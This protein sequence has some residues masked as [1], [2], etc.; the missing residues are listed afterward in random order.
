M[1]AFQSNDSFSIHSSFIETEIVKSVISIN[2]LNAT[3]QTSNDSDDVVQKIES[4]TFNSSKTSKTTLNNNTKD[5]SIFII[6]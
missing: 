1:H 2:Y 5:R 4:S 6:K 3:T